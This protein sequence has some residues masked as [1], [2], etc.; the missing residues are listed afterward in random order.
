[1]KKTVIVT[2][3]TSGLGFYLSLKLHQ[4]GYKVAT[5][6][7]NPRKIQ[8]LKDALGED[9]IYASGDIS[10]ETFINSFVED[11]CQKERVCG[12]INNA[13]EG[14]FALPTD[15][16]DD[17][18]ERCLKGVK[19][20]MFVTGALLRENHETDT[21]IINILSTAAL[22]GKKMEAAYCMAKWAQRGYTESLKDAYENTSVKVNGVYVGG[23]NTNLYV[24]SRDY[25]SEEKQSTFMDPEEIAGKIVNAY[26]IDEIEEDLTI[27]RK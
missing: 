22:K 12:A 6:S 4:L 13:C 3:G 18:I 7:R 23:M 19:G 11:I 25:I 21:K 27:K 1:M 15:I 2:G 5:V 8:G 9:L 26:F 20:M 10:D 14:F 24:S 16:H 17:D